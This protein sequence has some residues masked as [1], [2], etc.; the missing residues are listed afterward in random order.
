MSIGPSN[1][2]RANASS[3]AM[4]PRVYPPSN[5]ESPKPTTVSPSSERPVACVADDVVA[6]TSTPS[7]CKLAPL[8]APTT[9]NEQSPIA[10]AIGSF[11]TRTHRS[12]LGMPW[13]PR[14]ARRSPR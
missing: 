6:N 2:G 1:M 10:G 7:P 8:A 4:K 12:A 14:S 5:G 3:F 13:I 9:G 11:E